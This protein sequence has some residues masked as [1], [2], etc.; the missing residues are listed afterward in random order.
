LYFH[1]YQYIYLIILKYIN[2]IHHSSS[3]KFISAINILSLHYISIINILHYLY[4]HT[5]IFI[6]CTSKNICYTNYTMYFI[7]LIKYCSPHILDITENIICMNSDIQ[8]LGFYTN[9][10]VFPA[11]QVDALAQFMHQHNP[12]VWQYSH[13][14]A[15]FGVLPPV[16]P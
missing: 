12:Y 6:I 1:V 3:K 9:N 11:G 5:F 15:T 16:P 2:L 13:P 4:Y 10:G 14:N 8:F 7:L